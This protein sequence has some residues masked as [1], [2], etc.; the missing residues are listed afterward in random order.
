VEH[1]FAPAF[2]YPEMSR[3]F[4]ETASTRPFSAACGELVDWLVRLGCILPAPSG[5][6]SATE[7]LESNDVPRDVER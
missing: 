1:R 5:W 4:S 6:G 2:L 3:I 7:L